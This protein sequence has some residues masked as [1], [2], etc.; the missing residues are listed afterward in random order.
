MNDRDLV[1]HGLVVK[2]HAPAA[3][4]AS[5]IGLDEARVQSVLTE[6]VASGRA[7]E[8]RHGFAITPLGRLALEG[9]YSLHFAQLRNDAQFVAAYESFERINT[10]LKKIIT[11][12]QTIEVAGERVAND[13]TD[14]AYDAGVMDRLGAVHEQVEPVLMTLAA[15]LPRIS[16][17]ARKLLS[18][19]EAAEG[20][21]KEWVSDIKRESYHTLWFELHED[22]LRIMGKARQE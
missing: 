22:L 2:R 16:I 20:G 21:E 18:A 4:I 5:L 19:L 15:S 11:E 6:A 1:F 8:A 17:Y 7:I 14:A 13:H 3:A 12:W 10:R 9:R